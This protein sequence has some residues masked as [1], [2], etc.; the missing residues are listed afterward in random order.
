MFVSPSSIREECSI[1]S[2]A[3]AV[4]DGGTEAHVEEAPEQHA[5]D[6]SEEENHEQPYDPNAYPG[7]VLPSPFSSP[8]KTT[9][10]LFAFDQLYFSPSLL[11]FIVFIFTQH[12]YAS[13][14]C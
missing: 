9:I 8:F 2:E 13:W 3:K 7:C 10:T 1:F 12:P 11:I 5:A 4:S 6:V 14:A